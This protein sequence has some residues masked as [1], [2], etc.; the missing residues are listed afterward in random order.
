MYYLLFITT[1]PFN[2]TLDFLLHLVYTNYR[3]VV[4]N[5][6]VGERV[7]YGLPDPTIQDR[8]PCAIIGDPEN[9]RMAI[10][11]KLG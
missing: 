3:L 8:E 7:S 1:P 5:R 6:F 9:A 4:A 2:K 10:F 11:R